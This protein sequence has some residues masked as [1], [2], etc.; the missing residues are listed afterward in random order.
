MFLTIRSCDGQLG[1][2]SQVLVNADKLDLRIERAVSP[3]PNTYPPFA[4]M[5]ES[6]VA[7]AVAKIRRNAHL[8]AP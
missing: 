4:L 2:S 1:S 6:V 8:D 3:A 5:G 7:I